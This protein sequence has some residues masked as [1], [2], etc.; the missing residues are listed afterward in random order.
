VSAV[1]GL[2]VA[3]AAAA[4]ATVVAIALLFA[5]AAMLFVVQLRELGEQEPA[6][7]DEAEESPVGG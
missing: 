3:F 7:G 5:S 2:L 1:P 6:D 4:L